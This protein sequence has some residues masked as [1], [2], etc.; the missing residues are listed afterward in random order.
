MGS[1]HTNGS[2]SKDSSSKASFKGCFC[3][4]FLFVILILLIIIA[5]CLVIVLVLK[6]EKP[7]IDLKQVTVQIVGLSPIPAVDLASSAD[8]AADVAAAAASSTPIRITMVFA[9]K[10]DN[11]LGIKFTETKFIV[12]YNRIPL[13]DGS[14]PEFYMSAY[15]TRSV[16][17]V[18]VVNR[19]S[20]LQIDGGALLRDAA[21]SDQIALRVT[22]IPGAKIVLVGGISSPEVQV[23]VDC[24]IT[25]SPR[26]QAVINQSCSFD[27][28]GV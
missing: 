24:S 1:R 4:L 8:V 28:V 22:G 5:A 7:Q 17:T 10:N 23:A 16:V 27:G 2:H 18:I 9:V 13:G 6:P 3:C 14:V 19:S 25:I 15:S 12:M 20:L 11:K 21:I 26:K